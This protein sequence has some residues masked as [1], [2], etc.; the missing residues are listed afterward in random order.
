MPPITTVTMPVEKMSELAFVSLE[1]MMN[2]EDVPRVQTLRT[3][4][5]IRDSCGCEGTDMDT[6]I[7]KRVRQSQE[8][9]KM[10]DLIRY[11]TYTFVEM[12][13]VQRAQEIVNHTR[14]LDVEDNFIK[15]FFICLGEG[16]GSQYPKYFSDKNEYP[17]QSQAVGAA[18]EGKILQTE[19]AVFDTSDLLPKEAVEQDPMIY[20]FFPLH[21]LNVTFGYFAI[22][23][24]GTHSCGK[25]FHSWLAI[26]GNVL[27]SM[28]L[29]HKTN[30][31]LEELNNMYVHDALTGLLNRRGFENNSRDFYDKSQLEKRT[32]A[33]F[34][35][36]MD[37]LKIVN[38]KFGHKQG[39]IALQTIGKAILN[40]A[41]PGDVC[42]RIGGDEFS[43]V[44]MDYNKQKIQG[45]MKKFNEYLENFNRNSGC[46]YLVGASCG[47][48]L[49]NNSYE[50]TLEA[51]IVK[52]DEHL[53]EAKRDKKRSHR[54]C[55]LRK[56]EV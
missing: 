38:D 13:D 35:I 17:K 53:Y 16:E 41:E 21:N 37:N 39:D 45:F 15:N 25:S 52:S 55:V 48:Y 43:V 6:A 29:R 32:M 14:L 42:A 40:A 19:T 46:P 36:D 2:G 34:S 27:E 31:L 26:L 50:S 22:S 33:I 24:E 4:P 44:G 1:R 11:N 30:T 20:Y 49:I 3:E 8:Y 47:W 7:K 5:V 56:G 23:Y 51:A 9:E 12:S 28:R 10:L 54:D 18:M